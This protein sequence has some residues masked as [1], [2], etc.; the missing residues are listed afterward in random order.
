MRNDY[1]RL[2]K[3]GEYTI[4]EVTYSPNIINIIEEIDTLSSKS[5][6]KNVYGDLGATYENL[7]FFRILSEMAQ[8]KGW[9]SIWLLKSG[10]TPIAME[11]YILLNI[12]K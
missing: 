12:A 7:K 3:L 10:N 6:K 2:S 11:K 8:E 4:N 9:L 5:W 1:N